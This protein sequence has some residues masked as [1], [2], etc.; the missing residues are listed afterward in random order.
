MKQM[1]SKHQQ[2]RLRI[3]KVEFHHSIIV[4]LI[5]QVDQWLL[6]KSY[7]NTLLN[8][9]NEPNEFAA[10]SLPAALEGSR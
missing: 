10:P 4:L 8:L 2:Q 9:R 3:D 6:N 5:E 7:V 1:A